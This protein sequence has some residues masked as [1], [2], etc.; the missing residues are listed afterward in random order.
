MYPSG[1]ILKPSK[2]EQIK[3]PSVLVQF[4]EQ[5]KYSRH[6]SISVIKKD[7]VVFLVFDLVNSFSFKQ[8]SSL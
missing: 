2:Q 7:M 8:M 6:S 3:L 4:C 1:I 5:G